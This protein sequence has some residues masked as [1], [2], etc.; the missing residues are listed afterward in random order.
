MSLF[1]RNVT[2]WMIIVFDEKPTFKNR[3]MVYH[4]ILHTFFELKYYFLVFS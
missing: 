4:A 2:I 3:V 1:C